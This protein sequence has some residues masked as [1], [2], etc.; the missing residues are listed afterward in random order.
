MPFAHKVDLVAYEDL[1]GRSGCFAALL[2]GRSATSRWDDA[3]VLM[4]VVSHPG[5]PDLLSSRDP[6][7]KLSA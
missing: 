3:A 6:K 1:Q 5:S 7:R 2:S 4:L